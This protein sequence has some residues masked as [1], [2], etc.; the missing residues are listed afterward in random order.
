LKE[1]LATA[2]ALAFEYSRDTKDAYNLT[3]Q[4][5]IEIVREAFP[6]SKSVDRHFPGTKY[7][8]YVSDGLERAK[9]HAGLIPEVA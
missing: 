6:G 9:N 3:R 1:L 5:F 7:L 2:S 4:A 8:H